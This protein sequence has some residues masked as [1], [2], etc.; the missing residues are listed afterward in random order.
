MQISEGR[1]GPSRKKE[2]AKHLQGRRPS[3]KGI[4][5]TPY[6]GSGLSPGPGL[7]RKSPD[8][9][10][11]QH[12]RGRVPISEAGTRPEAKFSRQEPS[13]RVSPLS[14]VQVLG[15]RTPSP[16]PARLAPPHFLEPAPR[17]PAGAAP[18]VKASTTGQG[19]GRK[20]LRFLKVIV[21]QARDL[22]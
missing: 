14:R 22:D 21:M 15:P 9:R 7:G 11:A 18:K 4:S 6:Y 8:Y 5:A 1:P 2:T 20:R 12:L 10:P 3:T 19:S 13:S 17:E 16:P